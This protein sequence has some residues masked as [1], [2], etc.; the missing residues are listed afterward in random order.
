LGT[1]SQAVYHWFREREEEA[2]VWSG[3]LDVQLAC[4]ALSPIASSPVALAASSVQADLSEQLGPLV[5]ERDHL[6][7]LM[8]SPDGLV[9]GS[10]DEA[11][12]GGRLDAPSTIALLARIVGGPRYAGIGLPQ[13]EIQ[14]AGYQ[15]ATML[16]GAAV[17]EDDGTVPCVLAF[18]IDPERDFTQILQRGR[19]GESGES[20]AFDRDGRLISR[21]RHSQRG[22][23]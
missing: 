21:S 22:D 9:L 14:D 5:E 8:L 23:P 18:L 6:G 7:Y 19:M 4:R 3:H 11:M 15:A 10:G 20:Y 1:T 13:S 16:V 12:I 17:R 2:L